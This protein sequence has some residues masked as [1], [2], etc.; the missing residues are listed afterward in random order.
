MTTLI[1]KKWKY[2][3]TDANGNIIRTINNKYWNRNN[4]QL[5]IH[6][7][8]DSDKTDISINVDTEFHISIPVVPNI[9]EPRRF[10][11]K[12]LKLK[13]ANR[14]FSDE[15]EIHD[16]TADVELAAEAMKE[17][18][19]ILDFFDYLD[20]EQRN[21]NISEE[22]ENPADPVEAAQ[23][24][25]PQAP[26]FDTDDVET[27]LKNCLTTGSC[28]KGGKL[29]EDQKKAIGSILNLKDSL[30]KDYLER[31]LQNGFKFKNKHHQN[32][33]NKTALDIAITVAINDMTFTI[34]NN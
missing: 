19:E 34:N 5:N 13:L 33:E 7:F 11:I 31:C 18:Q 15:Y 24:D 2:T 30:R 4:C 10:N 1:P 26:I 14:T 12:P 20:C 28:P 27:G 32:N 21:K 29:D 9:S 17:F 25:A 8:S 16:F 3:V 22:D 23:H 6:T